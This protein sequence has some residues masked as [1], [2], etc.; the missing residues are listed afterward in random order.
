VEAL[1]GLA[2]A[3]RGGRRR[4]FPGGLIAL[5]EGRTLTLWSQEPAGTPAVPPAVLELPAGAGKASSEVV[6]P[7]IGIGIRVRLVKATQ[8]SADPW[9]NAPRVPTGG[10]QGGEN[11]RQ[12]VFDRAQLVLPLRVRARQEGDRIQLP[13]RSA[14]R[15]VKDLL[16]AA[17]VPRRDRPGVPILVDGAN[18]Q[19]RVL[20]VA[21]IAR[22]THAPAGAGARELIEVELF[23]L[24]SAA[25]DRA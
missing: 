10:S 18:V 14:P 17:G 12:A 7:E 22:S 2:S 15:K 20:W 23:R 1:L 8:P 4:H 5:R 11:A 25:P 21:G 13:G 16:I 19:E 24:T 3:G 6:W 9:V